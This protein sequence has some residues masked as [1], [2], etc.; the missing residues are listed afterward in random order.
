MGSNGPEAKT[1]SPT[2]TKGKLKKPSS[3][4]ALHPSSAYYYSHYYV[5]GLWS[6]PETPNQ[7][8]FPIPTLCRLSSVDN[9]M[10]I[11]L[12]I[13]ISHTMCVV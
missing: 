2:W 4:H 9:A 3:P 12:G 6:A 5:F 11:D 8:V 1:L 13:F 7:F 10:V